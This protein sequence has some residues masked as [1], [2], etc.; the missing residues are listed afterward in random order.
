MAEEKQ[1]GDPANKRHEPQG[2]F[3]KAQQLDHRKLG[4]EEER[5]RNLDV[6]ERFEQMRKAAIEEVGG[7]H[8]L[9]FPEWEP[10]HVADGPCRQA[11]QQEGHEPLGLPLG[12]EQFG[13]VFP[14]AD[15]SIAQRAGEV[16]VV[17]GF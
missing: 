3:R 12:R 15:V 17:G 5:R 10:Q 6:V 4:P 2:V 16:R 14:G 7:Q 1:A 11:D 8:R 13:V 9:V